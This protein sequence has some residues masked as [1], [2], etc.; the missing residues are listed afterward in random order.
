VV[1]AS[2]LVTGVLAF[3]ANAALDLWQVGGNIARFVQRTADEWPLF[4][5]GTLVV[6]LVVTLLV[7]LLGRLWI[8]VGVVSITTVLLGFANYQKQQMLMEPLY[9]T[10]LVFV[11]S[12]K[13]LVGMVGVD[14]VSTLLTVAVAV[15]VAAVLVGRRLGRWFPAPDRRH[16][17]RAAWT[18]VGLRSLGAFVSVAA[19]A[20]LTHFHDPGNAFREAY[21]EH[22]AEWSPWNQSANYVHNGFVAGMLYNLP[23]VAM[24]KPPGYGPEAMQE[25]VARYSGVADRINRTRDPAALQD[26]NVV[27]VLGESFSDP[28]RVE[29]ATLAKDPIPF[30]RSL[31][32]RTTSGQMWSPKYGGGTANVEFE[33]LT[34]QSPAQFRPQMT[35]PYQM[36]VPGYAHFPSAVD[37]LEQQGL[38]T[39]AMHSFTSALYRR[40]TV[41]PTLGFDEAVFQDGMTHTRRLQDNPYVSDAA[42]YDETLAR[43][44]QAR[45]PQFLNV[46][47]MQNH[48]PMAGHYDR[49]I[50][51]Q[52]LSDDPEAAANVE[53][54]ARGL[55]HSDRAMKDFIGALERS[56]EKTVMLFYGDHLPPVWPRSMLTRRDTHQ[57][58]FFV[59]A[60]FGRPTP[61][62]LPTTSPIYFM[63]RVLARADAPVPPYYALLQRLE[64][65]VPAMDH[66]LMLGPDGTRISRAELPRAAQ[67]LLRDYRLVQYDLSVGQRYSAEEM[68][69]LDPASPPTPRRPAAEHE[70]L[71]TADAVRRS[72]PPINR[73]RSPASAG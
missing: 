46:V 32:Q 34:G 71:R 66:G 65:W 26:V 49:P 3:A 67:R 40:A 44:E 56:D 54:Y 22:G 8:T 47:T 2:V 52:G 11:T 15:G 50:P 12:P 48:F 70:D 28:T 23:L 64:R 24:S 7:A 30:T 45:D 5:L 38:D 17:P 21:E 18:V 27:L 37:Y 29:G 16:R 62:R 73:S 13:F 9:P 60:N 41:Y 42:T 59:Y 6:W 51:V 69:S 33:A 43:L 1:A 25:I 31:M 58:P 36:L 20:S 14:V 4:L 72:S 57:T 35:T 19:L 53:H 10:D 63:N 55:R 68:L 39:T 61:E